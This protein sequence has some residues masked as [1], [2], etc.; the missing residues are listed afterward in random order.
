M[1]QVYSQV[2]QLCH[3]QASLMSPNSQTYN[4]FRLLVT[5][6]TEFVSSA[7]LRTLINNS[8]SKDTF[9]I[10]FQYMY[11]HVFIFKM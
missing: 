3:S 11:I 5:K 8:E 2:D 7:D 9:N 4:Q 1:F 10:S 6:P